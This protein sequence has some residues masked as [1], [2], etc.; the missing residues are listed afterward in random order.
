[1]VGDGV[2]SDNVALLGL[3][4]ARNA[5][6]T[7][8]TALLLAAAVGSGPPA[9]THVLRSAWLNQRLGR[10]TQQL[11]T[12]YHPHALF[13][14][15]SNAPGQVPDENCDRAYFGPYY[16]DLW[17]GTV[18]WYARRDS[19]PGF[20]PLD[21]HLRASTVPVTTEWS[22]AD[23]LWD[24][25]RKLSVIG[26]TSPM[27]LDELK[28]VLWERRMAFGKMAARKTGALKLRL[29]PSARKRRDGLHRSAYMSAGQAKHA[30]A[31]LAEFTGEKI[32]EEITDADHIQRL[33]LL[34]IVLVGKAAHSG[35]GVRFCLDFRSLNDMLQDGATT[36]LP[37]TAEVVNAFSGC[38]VFTSLDEPRSFNQIALDDQSADWVACCVVDPD[39]GMRRFWRF[40]AAQLG[41][42]PLSYLAQ[43]QAEV[44]TEQVLLDDPSA[45]AA[46]FIDDFNLGHRTLP[47]ESRDDQ[48][49]RHLRALDTLLQ[50]QIAR[51]HVFGLKKAR[52]LCS[53]TSVMGCETD[54][55]S[56]RLDAKRLAGWTHL[57]VPE[58]PNLTWLLKF[59]G[60]CIYA[61][62]RLGPTFQRDSSPL[63]DLAAESE[64]ALAAANRCEPP[65]KAGKLRANRLMDAWSAVHQAAALRVADLVRANAPLLYWR[66]DKPCWVVSD[67]SDTGF[68]CYLQQQRDDGSMGIVA[69]LSRRWTEA[70][71]LYSVG[72][73]ELL[74]LLYF[75]RKYGRLTAF[76]SH[77]TF[78]SDHLNLL[79]ADQ[80]EH[81]YV[82]R[83]L[84][85]LLQWDSFRHIVHLPGR[86][87]ALS[88]FLSRY[89]YSE[90][91]F[92]PADAAAAPRHR[93]LP[94]LATGADRKWA[95]LR[96][97]GSAVAS[98]VPHPAPPPH[99][100]GGD[101][102][103]DPAPGTALLSDAT[104]DITR[105]DNVQT[106]ARAARTRLPGKKGAG[107]TGTDKPPP[108]EYL[109]NPHSTSYSPLIQSILHAQWGLSSKELL[110][111][112]ALPGVE[113]L[114]LDGENVLMRRGK[115]VVPHQVP[116]LVGML[117]SLLH[118]DSL[119][120][121]ATKMTQM[122]DN[123]KLFM[124][125]SQA[126]F[127][128]YCATCPDCQR[129]RAPEGTQDNAARLLIKPRAAPFQHLFIDYASLPEVSEGFTKL[130]IMVDASTRLCTLTPATSENGGETAEALGN[131]CRHYPKPAVVHTDGGPGFKKDFVNF[132]ARAHITVDRGTAYNSQGRGLV[133]N[134]VKKSKAALKRLIPPGKF[135]GWV[136]YVGELQPLLNQLPHRGLGGLSPQQVSMLGAEPRVPPLFAGKELDDT[137]DQS[138]HDLMESLRY[139]R[140]VTEVMGEVDEVSRKIAHDDALHDP[141][142]YK[143]GDWC[144][145]YH[146]RRHSSLD[147]FYRGPF[148]VL[149]V[150][151]DARGKP[152]G[153]YTVA[154]QLANDTVHTKRVEVHAG[155]MWPFNAERT[156]S[157]AE[158]WKRLPAGE[159][160]V[161][162]ILDHRLHGSGAQVLVKFF[163][164]AKPQWE[165]ISGMRLGESYG[166]N[167]VYKAYCA[168]R[169]LPL[170][171]G[172]KWHNAK[173]DT[174]GPAEGSADP[175]SDEDA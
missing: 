98:Q 101:G 20:A 138:W 3:D 70:Q 150:S 133:E 119:H 114:P 36:Q 94:T 11:P 128:H 85:E 130:I 145:I 86:A 172:P 116:Q 13:E 174:N 171:G 90:Q 38:T 154:R 66:P 74:A 105:I 48:H 125:R 147:S 50:A 64:R 39:T 88:D 63:W 143:V 60:T 112:R 123:A 54:G 58:S 52:F 81:P 5:G 57:Q 164:V 87:N 44:I 82:Q 148:K 22:S 167:Q 110:E 160:V 76:A 65:D 136:S 15:P 153:F 78:M 73:R 32:A 12:D 117:C 14:L 161:K 156:S 49:L 99:P 155:R 75:L 118:D 137:E 173:Q 62:P 6:F 2:R 166:W 23:A 34:P 59:L 169:G 80:L 113:V 71:R 1:M 29:K 7:E 131:W 83:W 170:D 69:I 124:H 16:P 97:R 55:V 56:T 37:D 45:V 30:I 115:L 46:A 168:S 33:N 129:A 84:W 102:G 43:E 61:A 10:G 135:A 67:A 152:N 127:A 104:S 106:Q 134:L 103:A 25:A 17:R 4:F 18:P 109:Y 111:T 149:E 40:H 35:G 165:F 19:E 24:D 41:L 8:V 163:M 132:C 95:S 68:C 107:P 72:G 159:G 79:T 26:D 100:S 122:M 9:A 120:V 27:V 89:C 146:E 47:G 91:E 162:G 92:A 77:T 144:L 140:A 158:H 51:G 28:R 96:R 42:K 31:A 53:S 126:V 21:E 175:D 108:V 141:V 142:G 93:P 121:G 151:T 157:D 139:L